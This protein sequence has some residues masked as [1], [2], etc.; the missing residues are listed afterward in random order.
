METP[1][2]QN[3][4]R[5]RNWIIPASVLL[6]VVLIGALYFYGDYEA[7]MPVEPESVSVELV[8]PPKEEPPPPPEE[9][10]AEEAKKPEPPPPPPPDNQRAASLPS[11]AIRPDKTQ[12]DA[13]DEPGEQTDEA[14]R[15]RCSRVKERLQKRRKKR[16]LPSRS[17]RQLRSHLHHQRQFLPKLLHCLPMLL[18][19]RSRP[20]RT[21]LF[22]IRLPLWCLCQGQ[23]QKNSSLR[24]RMPQPPVRVIQS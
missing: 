16:W 14:V 20:L 3:M 23:I 22:R 10:K 1:L 24:K 15:N 17:R 5:P 18:M 7:S 8:D 19:V 9:K 4:R 12:L 13:R 11:V 21:R 2:K 6:H